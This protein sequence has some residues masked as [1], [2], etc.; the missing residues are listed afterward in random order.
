MRDAERLQIGHD[1]G[2]G[3]EIEIGGELQAVGRDRDRRG[4][5]A[6]RCAS[7]PTMAGR[8][9]STRCPRSGF[10]WLRP[11]AGRWPDP[12]GWRR[13]GASRH[14]PCANWPSAGHCSLRA[15][16]R[17]RRPPGG[18]RS[19]LVGLASRSRTSVRR[20]R[21]AERVAPV[22]VEHGGISWSMRRAR[23]APRRHIPHRPRPVR[24]DGPCGRRRR[25]RRRNR[26]R[27]GRALSSPIPRP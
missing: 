21:A 20:F 19:A 26:R 4:H 11:M 6:I 5:F 13:G 7:A 18:A 10:P 2:G 16:R 27:T 12:T 3:V 14:R 1:A 15:L 9:R 23:R 22:P 8:A 24:R 25:D 17:R